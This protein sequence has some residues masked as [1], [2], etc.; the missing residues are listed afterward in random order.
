[1]MINK[2]LIG[3][4]PEAKR[5]IAGNVIAQ[6]VSLAVNIAVIFTLGNLL[7]LL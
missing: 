2:R 6:W 4:V 5:H 7:S 3:T 1:M